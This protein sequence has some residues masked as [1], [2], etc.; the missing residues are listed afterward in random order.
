MAEVSRLLGS[1]S[2][3]FPVDDSHLRHYGVYTQRPAAEGFFMVRIRI[4]GGDLTPAQLETIADLAGEFGRDLVDITVRQNMQLHWIRRQSLLDILGRLHAV[5]LSTS[6]VCGKSARNIVNCPVAGVDHDELFDTTSIVRDVSAFLTDNQDFSQLP[7]KLKITITGCSLLCVYPEISD[8]GIFAVRDPDSGR[9]SF[10]ARVGGGLSGSPR[11]ARDLGI[12]IDP[13]DVLAV[14]AAIAFVFRDRVFSQSDSNGPHFAVGE[15]EVV[16]FRCEVEA[17][18]GRALARSDNFL[19]LPAGKDRSHLGIHRQHASGSYYV[20]LSIFGGRT[21]GAD[22]RRLSRLSLEHGSGRVRTTNSQNIALL[23]IPE[24]RLALL[25]GQLKSSGFDYEPNWARKGMLAC[26]G[27]QFC[28]LA[29]TETKNRVAELESQLA[30]ETDLNE[31]IRISVTGCPN[32]CGQHHICDVGLEGSLT[33][34]DGVKREAFQVFLGGGV[35]KKESFGRRVGSRIPA[36]RLGQSLAALFRRYKALRSQEE[37]FQEFCLRHSDD[38]LAGFLRAPDLPP[39]QAVAL[40]GGGN[41]IKESREGPT[42][43]E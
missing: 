1:E 33:T 32:S 8:I 12:V 42:L 31:P 25:T 34:V 5:G 23:D 41:E 16:A 30:G 19:P 4:P 26:T 37:S 43:L 17:R 27:M 35:G 18:F 15:S 36:E 3:A 13:R 14:L 29:L 28:K 11:F 20:G 6:E 10:R 22:L 7:R 24:K 40:P 39:D 9:V 21:S 2:S 38:A